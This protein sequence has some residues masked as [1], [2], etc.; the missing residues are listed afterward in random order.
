MRLNLQ[1]L[2]CSEEKQRIA[3]FAYNLEEQLR[4]CERQRNALCDSQMRLAHLLQQISSDND[5]RG[6]LNPQYA[7]KISVELERAEK[8]REE[9][10]K[11]RM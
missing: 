6:Y 1:W 8:V 9:Q 2:N 4:E 10:W 5:I 11:S 7:A 3:E